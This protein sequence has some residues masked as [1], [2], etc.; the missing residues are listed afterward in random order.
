MPTVRYELED[1]LRIVGA[2]KGEVLHAITQLK[3]EVKQE[4]EGEMSIELESD[5]PDLLSIYGLGRAIR[6]YL[7]IERGLPKCTKIDL[8]RAFEIVVKGASLRP[9]VSTAVAR[10]VPFDSK[11]IKGFMNLQELLHLTIGR[12]RRKMAIGAH[13]LDKIRPPIVY[14]EAPPESKIVPL[15]LPEE[16]SLADVLE[17]HEKGVAYRHLLGGNRTFPVFVDSEGIFSFPPII[18]SERTKVTEDTRNLFIEMTGTDDRAVNCAMAIIVADLVDMGAMLE[19]VEMKFEDHAVLTPKLSPLEHVLDSKYAED[20][21]GIRLEEDEV[22]EMLTRMGHEVKN[23]GGKSFLVRMP[24]YRFDALHQI[25]L[26]EDLAIAYEYERLSPEL[27]PIATV[28]RCSNMSILESK[29]RTALV[30][31]SFQEVLTFTLSSKRLQCDLMNV[32]YAEELVELENPVTEE[33]SYLRRWILPGLMNFLAQNKHAKYPQMIFEIGYVF[34]LGGGWETLTSTYRSVAGVIIG[35]GITFN[36]ARAAV[37]AL[38]RSM[39]WNLRLV[40]E[41]HSSFIIGR[42]AAVM[43]G[44]ERVGIVGEIHPQILNNFELEFPASGFEMK[45]TGPLPYIK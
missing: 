33:L 2:T 12:D 32:N 27:P 11:S 31:L 1:L 22:E 17:G 23:L 45:L 7:G 18:N 16:M 21:I 44:D 25:D 29:I 14:T 6:G 28:G 37:E 36:D 20:I 30:G 13:D 9:V 35:S 34:K 40:G 39:G 3:G 43:R 15:G 42:S 41:I 19:G 10:D 4:T 38:G 24:P 8:K 5:R 26:V